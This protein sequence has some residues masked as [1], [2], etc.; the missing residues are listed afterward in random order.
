MRLQR[1]FPVQ[2]P[3][4]EQ[5]LPFV[6]AELPSSD[7]SPLAAPR[8]LPVRERRGRAVLPRPWD[9][10]LSAMERSSSLA[11]PTTVLPRSA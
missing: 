2:V 5:L 6:R 4:S 1:V 8:G 3:D 9:G 7:L 10:A 11:Y